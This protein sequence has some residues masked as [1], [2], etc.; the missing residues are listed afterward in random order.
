MKINDETYLAINR[1][2]Y[3]LRKIL[4][5]LKN[6]LKTLPLRKIEF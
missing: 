4:H 6:N 3:I 5:S 2:I 1:V